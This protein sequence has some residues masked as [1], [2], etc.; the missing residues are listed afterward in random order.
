MT[1]ITQPY[2]K[3]V[4]PFS[5]KASLVQQKQSPYASYSRNYFY[6]LLE[7]RGIFLLENGGYFLQ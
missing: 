3:R 1:P 5:R 2:Q 7:N 6:I 4:S